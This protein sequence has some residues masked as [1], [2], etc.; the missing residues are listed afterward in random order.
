MEG[1][2]I[3]VKSGPEDT[4]KVGE[5]LRIAAAMLGFDEP[6][7]IVFIDDGIRCLQPN[8]FSDPTLQDYLQAVADLAGVHA[9]SR[10]E[11][12]ENDFDPALGATLVDMGELVTMMKDYAAV[13]S[14]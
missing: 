9:V 6:A 3:V 8:A 2:M 10:L 4:D 1:L 5:S 7:T 11:D 13:A 14:F 12:S